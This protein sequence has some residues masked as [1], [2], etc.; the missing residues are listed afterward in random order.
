MAS[1]TFAAYLGLTV[2]LSKS[3]LDAGFLMLEARFGANRSAPETQGAAKLTASAINLSAS[4][5][6]TIR[7]EEAVVNIS[8]EKIFRKFPYFDADFAD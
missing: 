1:C 5:P 6:T 7:S 4:K 2:Y 8:F 3:V